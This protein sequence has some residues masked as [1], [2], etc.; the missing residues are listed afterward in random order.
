LLFK[1]ALKKFGNRRT[2]WEKG[3]SF[4]G[5]QTPT[6]ARFV[7]YF[8]IIKNKLGGLLPSIRVLNLKK[9]IIH[10]IKGN[11]FNNFSLFL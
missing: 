3:K 2:D 8:D 1:E 7:G 5:V 11:L 10:S 4:Q 6:Q 9:V